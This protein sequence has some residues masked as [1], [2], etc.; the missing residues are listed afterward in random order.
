[1]VHAPRNIHARPPNARP[2]GGSE[3]GR[4]GKTRKK[5][6]IRMLDW[7]VDWAGVGGLRSVMYGV[8]D[9]YVRRLRWFSRD[10]K[11]TEIKRAFRIRD[12]LEEKFCDCFRSECCIDVVIENWFT[13]RRVVK[14]EKYRSIVKRICDKQQ[15]STIEKWFYEKSHVQH[16]FIY[17]RCNL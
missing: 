6:K 14:I 3:G 11:L 12:V 16:L 15:R 2:K 17:G 4:A 5:I 9:V 1:M 8:V 13:S 7:R 10:E